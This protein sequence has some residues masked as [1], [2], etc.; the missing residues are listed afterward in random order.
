MSN[1]NLLEMLDFFL[2][3]STRDLEYLNGDFFFA[4]P[5]RIR[6]VENSHLCALVSNRRDDLD[7]ASRNV[8][9]WTHVDDVV[10]QRCRTE[11]Y[12]SFHETPDKVVG[13]GHWET[14]PVLA[15]WN[16][17]FRTGRTNI[18]L[19]TSCHRVS[20][21]VPRTNN[22]DGQ[23]PST[24]LHAKLFG[25]PLCLTCEYDKGEVLK[26]SFFH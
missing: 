3:F 11:L 8:I 7:D 4:L 18:F 5:I 21:N 19:H 12:A 20:Y 2:S 25:Y 15:K 10:H 14:R 23:A 1:R 6:H 22:G 13:I 26:E 16:I 9:Y 17:Y 24:G